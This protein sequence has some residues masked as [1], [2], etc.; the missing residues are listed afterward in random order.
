MSKEYIQIA[1]DFENQDQLE[2]LVAQLSNLGF[3][4]FNEEEAATSINNGVGMSSVLGT[5]AGLGEG[6]GHCKTFIL[7][8]DYMINNIEDE[9]CKLWDSIYGD[10]PDLQWT[11]NPYVWVYEFE[12]IETCTS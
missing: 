1:F 2:I 10:N 9:F 5:S 3:D 4:G 7:Q 12:R 11:A 6:A 8:Q